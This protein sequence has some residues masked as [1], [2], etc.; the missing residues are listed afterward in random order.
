M[1]HPVQLSLAIGNPIRVP[2]PT[3][4]GA[5]PDPELVARLHAEY[6][7]E[8]KATFERHKA[9]AGYAERTL[10]VLAVKGGRAPDAKAAKPKQS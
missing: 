5:D 4:A 7:A 2:K 1:P 9:S 3:T 10:S 6:V 8:L